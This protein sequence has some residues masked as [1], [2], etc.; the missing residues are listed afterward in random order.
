MLAHCLVAAVAT[1]ARQPSCAELTAD[2]CFACITKASITSY[3]CHWCHKD[4]QCHAIGSLASPCATSDDCVSMSHLSTCKD[5]SADDGCP[6]SATLP[7]QV[8][9]ALAGRDDALRVSWTTPKR[10]AGHPLVSYSRSPDLSVAPKSVAANS[11]HTYLKG[12]GWHHWAELPGLA[13]GEKYYYRI[14]DDASGQAGETLTFTAPRRA[15]DATVALGVFGDMGYQN[16][17]TRP[18]EVAVSGL[19]KAWSASYTY[20]VLRRLVDTATIDGVWH[21]GDIGYADDAFGHALGSF[22]YEAAYNGYMRWLEPIASRV[23][24]MV[25]PG[26][27]ESEC[28][29]PACLT[30][31]AAWGLPLSNFTAF[32]A[33]WAMPHAESSGTS[34]MW[35]SFDVG[36]LHVVSLNTETDWPGAGEEHTGDS[37]TASLP[38]GGFGRAGEYLRWLE[39]DL[40]RAHAARVAAGRGADG[41]RPWIV[42]GGHRPF[43][44]IEASHGELFRRYSVDAYFAGHSHSYR[45]ETHTFAADNST[46]LTIVVGGAGCDEMAQAPKPATVGL[47][48]PSYATGRY[49]SGVLRAN[50]TSLHWQLIDSEDGALVL[51]E[52]T[53][54]TK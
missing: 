9:I 50:A 37:H 45:R 7:E 5:K 30:G 16:S 4:L 2:G 48:L 29:S 12:F 19:K 42:A 17:S 36:P 38:A 8:H 10:P 35:Y 51:D 40:A 3:G 18:M 6:A 15:A 27:H 13:A 14:G 25:T 26:N 1:A 52:V 24:Y 32:N 53:L 11:S 43:E 49:A 44:E 33:R 22:T 23:P 41:A 54:I 47:G 46:I 31:H 39:A 34:N 21:L 20:G 28:H